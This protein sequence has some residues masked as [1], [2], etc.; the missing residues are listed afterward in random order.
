MQVPLIISVEASQKHWVTS[1]LA[2]GRQI[3]EQFPRFSK[4][5]VRSVNILI[6]KKRLRWKMPTC[7]VH[8]SMHHYSRCHRMKDFWARCEIEARIERFVL[9][10]SFHWNFIEIVGRESIEKDTIIIKEH[11]DATI[12]RIDASKLMTSSNQKWE[13]EVERT[14]KKLINWNIGEMVDLEFNFDKNLLKI[15]IKL[16]NKKEEVVD[17]SRFDQFVNL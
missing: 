6:H 16:P 1:L 14:Y 15:S 13:N 10:N 5:P 8:F 4:H 9:S 11:V 17:R 7:H 3:R 12:K 2:L